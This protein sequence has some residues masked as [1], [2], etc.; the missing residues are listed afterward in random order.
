MANEVAERSPEGG[1]RERHAELTP[2]GAAAYRPDIQGM[3]AIA[4]IAVILYHASGML[5]GGF[6]GVDVFFV[7]S[8]FV[9]TKSLTREHDRTGKISLLGFY[10]RRVHRLTPALL[11]LLIVVIPLSV[12]LA[13]LAAVRTTAGTGVAAA[14]LSANI[15]LARGPGYFDL[16]AESN[17]LAH[18]W[19]LSLEEQFYLVFP[20][21]VVI[22]TVLGARF[23]SR[24]T[25][26]IAGLSLFGLISLVGCLLAADADGALGGIAWSRVAFFAM[27]LRA[28][29]FIGGA[30]IALVALPTRTRRFDTVVALVGALLLVGSF[31]TIQE[32]RY[33]G[34]VALVP[35]LAAML[36]IAS[37]SSSLAPILSWKPLQRAGDV[38]YSWYLVH[39]PVMVFFRVNGVESA[40]VLALLGLATYPLAVWSYE[41][42]E[43]R[44]L[45]GPSTP[46]YRWIGMF[47]VS[48]V[49]VL[50]VGVASV[51]LV[52][53]VEDRNARVREAIDANV[54][55][56]HGLCTDTALS[57]TV[58]GC[59]VGSG[60]RSIAL[61]GD[62]NAEQYAGALANAAADVDASVTVVSENG[63]PFVDVTVI[64]FE[65][66]D[67]V[68]EERRDAVL[69]WLSGQTFDVVVLANAFDAYLQTPNE[70]V[71]GPAR[72]PTDEGAAAYT[73]ALAGLITQLEDRG[74][75]V[76][77]I[78]PIPKPAPTNRVRADFRTTVGCS[79]LGIMTGE[80]GLPISCRDEFDKATARQNQQ[81]AVSAE[82]EATST[83]TAVL[84]D[85]FE[86]LCDPRCVAHDGEQWV[87]Q[88]YGHVSGNYAEERITPLLLAAL[89]QTFAGRS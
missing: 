86:M 35:T 38:S 77:V 10:R 12:F 58:S 53:G 88:D 15:F 30:L 4:V 84:I 11:F 72:A 52:S 64:K 19:S 75:D 3:R 65:E 66:V 87:Y 41:A 34:L 20:A 36:L 28:W 54:A 80:S 48:A 85:P 29:Q 61:V 21:L 51:G 14:F 76:V 9:I 44:F 26:V 2:P 16:G 50:A 5:E 31:W 69:T 46:P 60:T 55:S 32:E 73:A 70:R 8:G 42:I 37:P 17:P 24:R 18:T 27:P 63:C 22:L 68:C 1:Q 45:V 78:H 71:V 43:Q 47:A 23:L 74:S 6:V 57:P 56:I 67:P 62:S 81:V 89:R 82:V 33:P 83:S 39:W 7:I 25:V 49:S 40:V 59:V 79:L 13:P